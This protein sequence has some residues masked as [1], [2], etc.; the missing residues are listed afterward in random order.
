MKDWDIGTH[1]PLCSKHD[2]KFFFPTIP[3]H[4]S[5]DAEIG[6]ENRKG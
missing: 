3:I 1:N 6:F 5:W 2:I 4:I